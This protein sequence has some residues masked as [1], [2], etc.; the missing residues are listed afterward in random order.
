MPRSFSPTRARDA[1]LGVVSKVVAAETLV[2]VPAVAL[3]TVSG[4]IV[5]L[6]VFLVSCPNELLFSSY[7][8][9]G[10][11]ILARVGASLYYSSRTPSSFGTQS[12]FMSA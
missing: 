2:S 3:V 9:V 6:W 5:T 4:N 8:N 1:V 10:S 7:L 11:L 12:F